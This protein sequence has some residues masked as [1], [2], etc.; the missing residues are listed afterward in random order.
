[1]GVAAKSRLL[2]K[3]QEFDA[4]AA[5]PLLSPLQSPVSPP[6]PSAAAA[7]AAHAKVAPIAML[8]DSEDRDGVGP[9]RS[10]P[11]AHG[12]LANGRQFGALASMKHN[13]RSS[14]DEESSPVGPADGVSDS[15]GGHGGTAGST[16]RPY[17]RQRSA[18]VHGR[19]TALAEEVSSLRSLIDE[20][21]QDTASQV[22][23]LAADSGVMLELVRAV[24]AA[25][26]RANRT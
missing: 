12:L 17:S 15:V 18:H 5:Q 1:M 16:A 7:A 8:V 13:A 3:P 20:V 23:G 22:S 24:I 10:V 4:P 11:S 14:E 26:R 6:P 21:R 2:V 9:L 25:K 19:V